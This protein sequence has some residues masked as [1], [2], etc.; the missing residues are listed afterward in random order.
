[1]DTRKAGVPQVLRQELINVH[2]YSAAKEKKTNKIMVSLRM[3][4]IL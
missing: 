4:D 3:Y 2:V 1:L